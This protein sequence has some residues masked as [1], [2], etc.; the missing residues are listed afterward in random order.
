MSCGNAFSS[1]TVNE[2]TPSSV[3]SIVSEGVGIL[4]LVGTEEEVT[5]IC[6]DVVVCPVSV[7]VFKWALNFLDGGGPEKVEWANSQEK[8]T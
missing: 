8:V 4:S 5:V 6:W 1:S 7:F 3:S 2:G